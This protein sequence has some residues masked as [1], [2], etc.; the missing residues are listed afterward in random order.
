MGMPP[1]VIRFIESFEERSILVCLKKI[2]SGSEY[3]PW[4]ESCLQRCDL[5]KQVLIFPPPGGS[6]NRSSK[7]SINRIT[8]GSGKCPKSRSQK[9]EVW[10][11]SAFWLKSYPIFLLFG[12]VFGLLISVIRSEAL[13]S[14]ILEFSFKYDLATFFWTYLRWFFAS[15]I[16]P[17]LTKIIGLILH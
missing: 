3:S 10:N 4:E 6:I 13:G 9:A 1:G 15:F 11:T 14:T 12:I 17:S 16:K 8:P 7:D 2:W 5:S